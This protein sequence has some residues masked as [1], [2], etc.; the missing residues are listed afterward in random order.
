MASTTD[1][2]RRAPKTARTRKR[3]ETSYGQRFTRWMGKAGLRTVEDA[4]EAT[5]L[6]LHSLYVIRRGARVPGAFT[7]RLLDAYM[8]GTLEPPGL[9]KVRARYAREDAEQDKARP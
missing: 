9:A 6:G 2:R 4:A 7:R 5:G 1:N 8:A 3:P